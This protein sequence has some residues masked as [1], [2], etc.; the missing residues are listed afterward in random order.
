MKIQQL[1]SQF[2]IVGIA[3]LVLAT[4]IIFLDNTGYM[5]NYYKGL[6]PVTKSLN[7]VY[8]LP[9]NYIKATFYIYQFVPGLVMAA[10]VIIVFSKQK[11]EDEWIK[12][13]RLVA[14]KVAFFCGPI[15]T[16]LFLK[17]NYEM[18]VAINLLL[19]WIIQ[20]SVFIYLVKVQPYL[21]Q[22]LNE[23]QSA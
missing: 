16:L 5:L 7:G 23:N 22:K 20:Y 2:K 4:A 14:Y 15:M 8:I 11:V 21:F 13:K 18:I 3:M 6:Q 1:P 17:F 10:L 9:A 12:Y 19:L